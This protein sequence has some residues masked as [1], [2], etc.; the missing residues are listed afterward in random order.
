MPNSSAGS[1]AVLRIKRKR[2]ADPADIL[3]V[4]HAFKKAFTDEDHK[5]SSNADNPGQ[6]VFKLAGTVSKKNDESL[7]Q[8]ILTK[9]SRKDV[10]K[11]KVKINP[12][13]ELTVD[14]INEKLRETKKLSRQ[15]S[16]YKVISKHRD[17]E[18]EVADE[19]D[20]VSQEMSRL[21]NLY[22]VVLDE[23]ESRD[24]TKKENKEDIDPNAILCNSVKMIREK[25]RIDDKPKSNLEIL[26]NDFVYD[27]YC[28]DDNYGALSEVLDIVHLNESQLVTTASDE[29]FNYYEDDDDSNDENNWRNDYPDED[30]WNES[31]DEETR[32]RNKEFDYGYD[33]D[34]MFSKELSSDEELDFYGKNNDEYNYEI[35]DDDEYY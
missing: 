20:A 25:L 23:D 17:V 3:L 1:K 24:V 13:N 22:D 27:V 31:S 12:K 10:H 2:S 5:R 11:S 14:S 9:L 8:E 28:A 21:Y 32:Y 19:V 29:E 26:E 6:R 4:S 34:K 33:G 15:A 16:R 30:E 7:S 18:D 35:V